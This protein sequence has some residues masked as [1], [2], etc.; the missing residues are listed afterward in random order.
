MFVVNIFEPVTNKVVRTYTEQGSWSDA[1]EAAKKYT[2]KGL[3]FSI[4]QL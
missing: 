1:R 4:F 2:D 3:C